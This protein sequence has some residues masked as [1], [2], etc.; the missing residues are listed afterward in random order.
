MMPSYIA[1]MPRATI[2]VDIAEANCAGFI[3]ATKG[4]VPHFLNGFVEGEGEDLVLRM[5]VLGKRD[6]RCDDTLAAWPHAVAVVDQETNRRRD[7]V[8][9]KHFNRLGLRIVDD[10]ERILR[11]SGDVASA[12]VAD[13]DVKDHELGVG[14]EGGTILRGDSTS[15]VRSQ[16]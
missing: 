13:R 12:A 4:R 15:E 11:E 1:V 6:G 8:G 10:G 5:R 3:S 9:R 16:K 2:A 14:A 7:L